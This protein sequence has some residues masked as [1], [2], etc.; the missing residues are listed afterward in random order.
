MIRKK[1]RKKERKAS[2]QAHLLMPCSLPL[3]DEVHGF[4]GCM[5]MF[6]SRA[7]PV[8][9]HHYSIFSRQ[10]VSEVWHIPQQ[11]CAN[12]AAPLLH[13]QLAGGD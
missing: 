9:L 11:S 2:C 12:A 4:K 6:L 3:Q 5:G 8:L 7:V 10:E 1:E 13:L